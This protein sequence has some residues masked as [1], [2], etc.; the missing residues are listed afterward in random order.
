MSYWLF[1]TLDTRCS[2]LQAAARS[3]WLAYVRGLTPFEKPLLQTVWE[4]KSEDPKY[5]IYHDAIN[6]GLMKLKKYY[7]KFDEKP[8]YFLSLAP[9]CQPS[10]VPSERL[11][12]CIQQ[13][14]GD[15]RSRLRSDRF[16][17]LEIFGI[18]AHIVDHAKLNSQKIERVHIE[19]FKHHLHL[20][21]ELKAWDEGIVESL[22]MIVSD[23]HITTFNNIP[24]QIRPTLRIPP[25]ALSS[26]QTHMEWL[27]HKQG[28]FL[29]ANPPL[30]RQETQTNLRR[31]RTPTTMVMRLSIWI[32]RPPASQPPAAPKT[33]PD[34]TTAIQLTPEVGIHNARYELTF[35]VIEKVAEHSTRK[36]LIE[37]RNSTAFISKVVARSLRAHYW[38]R[39]PALPT[40]QRSSHPRDRSKENRTA[41]FHSTCVRVRATAY[42]AR[43]LRDTATNGA[44]H[45]QHEPPNRHGPAITPI[46]PSPL[47]NH[48]NWADDAKITLKTPH[49]PGP[50]STMTR[51]LSALYPNP[52]E[53]IWTLRQH[54]MRRPCPRISQTRHGLAQPTLPAL[55]EATDPALGPIFTCRHPD[56]ITCGKLIVITAFGAPSPLLP[57]LTLPPSDPQP[58]RLTPPSPASLPPPRPASSHL[59]G[60]DWD[61]D[62]RLLT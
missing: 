34:N 47:G 37:L 36:V 16:E 15:R 40:I 60:L 35:N 54:R 13:T 7:S 31:T 26:V 53:T 5:A 44:G 11:F 42:G 45:G 10:S 19:D 8:V 56:G 14:V 41:R 17:E 33:L 20:D 9:P 3:P 28:S 32:W 55:F 39:T 22:L 43:N 50:P 29:P 58:P 27:A 2:V 46:R 51:D 49:T 4:N 24:S 6:D 25:S 62:P 12:S 30:T 38:L 18:I 23:N 57:H 48:T 52:R 21:S 61:S 1:C 59:G